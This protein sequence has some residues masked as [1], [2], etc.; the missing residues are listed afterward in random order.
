SELGLLLAVLGQ[1]GG[2]NLSKAGIGEIGTTAMGTPNGGGIAAPAIGGEEKHIGVTTRA[3]DHAIRFMG[4]DFTI[5]QVAGD[6]ATAHAIVG[7]HIQHLMAVKHLDRFRLDLAGEGAVG[8][9]EKLL[10]GLAAGVK[11]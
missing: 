6:D 7:H 8:T 2:V 11:G 9:D 1:A 4:F 3:Y 5:E 10:A